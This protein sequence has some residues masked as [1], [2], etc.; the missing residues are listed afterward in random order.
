MK[1]TLLITAT[2]VSLFTFGQVQASESLLE[3]PMEERAE[4]YALNAQA[5]AI[6]AKIRH[7]LKQGCNPIHL[8]H[9][10]RKLREKAT[11]E[12]WEANYLA[13]AYYE[14]QH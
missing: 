6:K 3:K 8:R 13:K 9:K 2:A 1:K 4:A 11:E 10:A 5:S 12:A 7:A 14:G